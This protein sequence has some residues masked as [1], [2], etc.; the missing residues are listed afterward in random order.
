MDA[1]DFYTGIVV[2]AY[3]RLKST[4]FDAEPYADFV[5]RTGGPG[6]EIGCGDGEPLLEL[7]RQGLDV[8][9]VDASADM[10]DRCRR[11]AAALGVEVTLHHQR[12]EDLALDRRFRS[13]YLAGPTFNL[14]PDDEVAGRALEAIARQLTGDGRALIPL[15]IPDR[16]PPEDLGV[17]R[18]ATVD[19]GVL[20]RYTAVGEVYDEAARTRTTTTRYERH[21][22]GA[23]EA[24]EREWILHWYE[25]D[26]FRGMCGRAGLEVT[27]VDAED[28]N[29]FTVT[30]RR[31]SVA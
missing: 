5:R 12:M 22:G 9:G 25:Q 13:I 31:R 14:L 24:V 20:L 10:L 21:D 6:L 3:A 8:E 26:R 16:T 28:A 2:E 23:V 19:G 7:R 27:A 15:W 30:V 1:A 17:S 18:E 11:N 4:S 29:D